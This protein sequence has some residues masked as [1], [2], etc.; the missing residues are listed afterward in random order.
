MFHASEGLSMADAVYFAFQY[1]EHSEFVIKL[2]NEKRIAHARR[3]VSGDET[4]RVNVK[5]T[6]IRRQ[7][8][9]NPDWDF[10]LDPASISFFQT[11]IEVC[12]AHPA[13]VGDH[14]DVVGRGFLP[15]A[16]WCPWKST[17]LREV[18]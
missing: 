3:I 8:D 1:P 18:G 16:I 2:T 9:Y 15:G 10:H 4:K 12:D 17:V 5:G 7:V 11:E 14:L 13:Y 6:I